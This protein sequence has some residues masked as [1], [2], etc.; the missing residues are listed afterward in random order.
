[1]QLPI[2]PVAV[3]QKPTY[4]L[5]LNS[6]NVTGTTNSQ[7]QFDF[8]GGSY[9]VKKG[10]RMCVKNITIPYSWFNVNATVYNNVSFQYIFTDGAGSHTRTV[11]L[12]NGFYTVSDI[13]NALVA[14]M[15]AAGYFLVDS[16]GQNVYYL[17][18]ANDVTFYANQIIALAF[19]T[20]LPS[21]YTNPNTLT[22]P[23]TA[24]TPQFVVL[25]TNNFGALI[26]FAAASYPAAIQAT[27]FSVIGTVLPVI[28]PVNNVVVLCNLVNNTVTIPS[29][30]LDSFP[31]NAT[32]GSNINYAPTFA[33]WVNLN[34]GRY[35]NFTISFVDQNFNT[36]IANDD[37]VTITLQ[38]EN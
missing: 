33:S 32:F 15:T 9:I 31:I 7:Y 35:D 19:P 25:S 36:I 17:S 34:A 12:T 27:N 5:V 18:I 13:N 28:T 6:N 2:A 11:T 38:I 4:T 1:M 3:E 21:G 22:F 14:D 24:S 8:I 23:A 37:N 26:G 29:N 16:T 20:A 30:I 10:S